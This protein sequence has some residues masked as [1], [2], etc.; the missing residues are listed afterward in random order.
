MSAPRPVLSPH[1]G[2]PHWLAALLF[3]LMLVLLMLIGSWFL[4]AFTPVDPMLNVTLLETDAPPAADSP[5]EPA[6]AL[7]A[8]LD[9]TIADGKTL[10]GQL[11]RLQAELTSKV[12]WCKP[13][14]QLPPPSLPADRWAK[15]DLG[16]LKGCWV[17]GHDVASWRG[18]IGSPERED[19]CTTKAARMCFDAAGRGQIILSAVCPIAGTIYC[20]SPITAKFADDG[21]FTTAAP[22]TQCQRGPPTLTASA[23]GSCRRVDDYHALCRRT[24]F[25]PQ[26]DRPGARFE[27]A[28]FRREP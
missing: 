26:F 10:A 8:S 13:T 1:L 28:E 7:R 17:L 3:G 6:P 12:A 4:H 20:A 19:N 16:M 14:E 9:Q 5:A 2:W 23:T 25:I 15:K 18:E 21:T 24:N 27:E 22:S 11:A